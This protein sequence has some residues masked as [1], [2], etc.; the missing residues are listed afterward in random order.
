MVKERKKCSLYGFFYAWSCAY[1][2][3]LESDSC[4]FEANI[5]F[6]KMNIEFK[7]T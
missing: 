3:I 4:L 2:E 6:W 7:N 1:V 5:W